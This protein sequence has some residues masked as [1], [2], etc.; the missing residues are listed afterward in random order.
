[1]TDLRHASGA[2]RARP[3]PA[4]AARLALAALA[5]APA[6]AAAHA[7]L[8]LPMRALAV[9]LAVQAGGSALAVAGLARAYPHPRLG[10]C[11]LVTLA[12]LAAAAV[13]A[14]AAAAPG[15]AA[16]ASTALVALAAGALALDGADGWLARRS[17]LASD[18]GARFHM[19][20]DAA[21]GAA[22]AVL[23]L[24]LGQPGGPVPAAAL[25]VLGFARY[26]FVAAAAAWPW[27][28]GPLPPRLSRK[29]VCVAQIA[30]LALLLLPGWPEGAK[31]AT[32]LTVAGLLAWSFGRDM[33]HLA[34]T[35]R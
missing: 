14:G 29:A 32:A 31:A 3:I 20:V 26:A 12:R 10:A 16:P 2:I 28:D 17:G 30:T 21:L 19:E 7:L 13:I 25:L 4:P 24:G 27:L 5:L 22:L 11:N 8:G 6:V 35:A 9:A 23:L 15:A 1:M 18:I 33:A 34:R